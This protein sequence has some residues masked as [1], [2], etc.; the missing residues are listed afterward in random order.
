MEPDIQN[1]M[2]SSLHKAIQEAPNSPDCEL[3]YKV[4]L[5]QHQAT[6]RTVHYREGSVIPK[7]AWLGIGQFAGKPGYYLFYYDDADEILTDTYH[8][9]LQG[10]FDQA[11]F[12]FE[13]TSVDWDQTNS[14]RAQ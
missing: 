5:D 14:N 2:R 10:A 7:P 12:E 6:G 13:V 3:L 11:Q 8:D 1:Q 4:R 9:Q